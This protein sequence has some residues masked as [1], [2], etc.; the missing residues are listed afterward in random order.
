MYLVLISGICYVNILEVYMGIKQG[1]ENKLT[2]YKSVEF[3]GINELN[4]TGVV[5]TET[6]LW[7]HVYESIE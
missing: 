6:K 4:W 2:I 1:E 7:M 3:F 5:W